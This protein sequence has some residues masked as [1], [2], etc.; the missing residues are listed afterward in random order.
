MDRIIWIGVGGAAGSILRYLV[1]TGASQLAARVLANWFPLGTLCVNAIGSFVIGLVMR[2]AANGWITE[3]TR[4]ALTAGL[5]G[6]F[7]TFSSF[8][9]ETLELAEKNQTGYAL[10]NVA[11]N[12]VVSLAAVWLGQELANSLQRATG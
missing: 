10:L 9:F 4:L 7:T 2:S 1:S 3:P 8:A 12:C 6:G 11:L 5:L